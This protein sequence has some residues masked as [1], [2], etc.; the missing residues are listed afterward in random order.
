[1]RGDAT[2]QTAYQWPASA[3]YP[4][5]LP[6]L[7]PTMPDNTT[8]LTFAGFIYWYTPTFSTYKTRVASVWR[9]S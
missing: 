9:S 1:M 8:L 3:C 7:L 4:Y 5:L 6:V 2:M